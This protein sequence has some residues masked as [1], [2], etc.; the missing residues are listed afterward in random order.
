VLALKLRFQI[1]A[2]KYLDHQ[3]I[4]IMNDQSV[5]GLC[6]QLLMGPLIGTEMLEELEII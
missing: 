5:L 4:L 1:R 6:V 2:V 3:V